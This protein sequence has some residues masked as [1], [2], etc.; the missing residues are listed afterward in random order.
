MGL[1]SV[2][3]G[4]G[5]IFGSLVG[6]EAAQ[7]AGLDGIF[8]AS[9][10]L[11][12]IALLPLSPAPAL[13]APGGQRAGPARGARGREPGRWLTRA[14]PRRWSPR[15]SPAGPAG[16]SSRRTTSRRPPGSTSW[17]R[18]GTR[19]TP[20]SRPT[21]SSPSSCP[22]AA[23]SAATRS[24]SCG[25]RRRPSRS[26]LNGSGRAPSRRADAEALRGPRAS[27]GSRCAAR[28]AI[29]VPGAVR[30][31]GDAHGRWGRL[32]RDAV[33]AAG[34]RARRG[35]L[36][37]VGRARR[38]RSTGRRRRSA[39]SRGRP[40]FRSVWQPLGRPPRPGRAGPPAG[41]RQ[42]AADA[43]GRGLRRLLRR[44]AGRADRA[45]AHDGR[46]R[47]SRSTTCASSGR[48]GR[49]RSRPPTAATR[50]TTHPP[51]SSGLVA[52]EILNVLGRFEP[53]SA[54]RFDG[55]GWSDPAWIHLQLE[56]AKLAF[57]D[58]DA[59]LADPAFH[60]VPV[61]RLLERRPRRRARGAD[62]PGARGPRP[63]AGPRCSSAGRST[64]PSS[65]PTATR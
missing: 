25:T 23:G 50:V 51:N 21:R 39:T 62:R 31:W 15:G 42:H 53:P 17:R 49:R 22:T 14:G 65:T 24:G 11:L 37:G 9:F 54:A 52:L 60:D 41:P 20:P 3:L 13:R 45:R 55:R 18:A 63:A 47:R 38:R 27:T 6:G 35:R 12:G 32:S 5:Q 56:A 44:R 4:L 34:D 28:S 7:R 30:S 10:I 1:Y 57:A 48:S 59:H 64:S 29:T 43:R 61:E 36:P 2:F 46:G 58:R 8:V 40:G 19:S 16:R 26:A 33:L